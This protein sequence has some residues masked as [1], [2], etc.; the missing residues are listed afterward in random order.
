ML[1]PSDMTGK[2]ALVTGAASGLGKATALRLAEVGADLAIVDLEADGLSGTAKEIKALGRKVLELP[3]NLMDRDQCK[4]AVERTV[5]EMGRLDSVCNIAGVLRCGA[6]EDFSD[7]DWDM[8]LKVNL[9]A[10]FFVMRAA[11]PHMVDKESTIVNVTS[12]AGF[13]EQAYFAAYCTSKAA[14]TH[15]TKSLAFEYIKSPLRI[16]AVAP[17]GMATPLVSHAAP[18]MSLDPDLYGRLGSFK[19]L[20]DLSDVTEV[21]A[22]LA[23]PASRSFHG[24]CLNVDAGEIIG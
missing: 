1:A 20:C 7:N 17:G 14:L 22:F 6:T 18:A 5:A 4:E 12:S 16:N 21:V 23:S 3:L 24:A 13:R 15:L 19:G 11:I 2:V 10:P 9:E 8:V